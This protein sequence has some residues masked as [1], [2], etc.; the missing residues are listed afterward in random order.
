[1]PRM[2]CKRKWFHCCVHS[3]SL[4]LTLAL[5]LFF[6][7]CIF[8]WLVAFASMGW[9]GNSPNRD[10]ERKREIQGISSKYTWT[11]PSISKLQTSWEHVV[12]ISK[13]TH[14]T[15]TFF[16]WETKYVEC[17]CHRG[18]EREKGE[19]TVSASHTIWHQI[20]VR[21]FRKTMFSHMTTHHSHSVSSTFVAAGFVEWTCSHRNDPNDFSRL[22][23]HLYSF[24][25]FLRAKTFSHWSIT[26]CMRFGR[27]NTLS[28][29]HREKPRRIRHD[30]RQSCRPQWQ[31]WNHKTMKNSRT[32][33]WTRNRSIIMMINK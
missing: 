6:R 31:R 19:W 26:K 13:Q 4:W 17:V 12:F 29:T 30:P 33:E 3:S 5:S 7:E 15:A 24:A 25:F 16:K 21:I 14:G 18:I 22:R 8:G 2:K 10:R 11:P 23:I 20:H 32:S 27:Q 28:H 9:S 1:M